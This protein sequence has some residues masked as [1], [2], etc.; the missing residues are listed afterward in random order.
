MTLRS[1]YRVYARLITAQSLMRTQLCK[2]AQPPASTSASPLAQ[3]I[4]H[5]NEVAPRA[6][7]DPLD[8][9]ARYQ[10][11]CQRHLFG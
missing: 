7:G 5:I 1:G 3:L 2:L 10:L 4:D 9:L 6:I 8:A 11:R